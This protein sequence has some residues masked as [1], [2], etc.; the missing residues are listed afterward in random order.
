MRKRRAFSLFKGCFGADFA[1]SPQ[2]SSLYSCLQ[3]DRKENRDEDN[4]S[5]S[6]APFHG[7]H[8]VVARTASI[9]RLHSP[10]ARQECCS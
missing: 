4:K 5:S 1:A 6:T 9:D 7:V 2:P 3:R 10:S 8:D